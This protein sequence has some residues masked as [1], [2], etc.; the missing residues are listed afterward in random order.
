MLE[1]I[2]GTFSG[3]V[4]KLSGKSTITEKNI[5]IRKKNLSLRNFAVTMLIPIFACKRIHKHTY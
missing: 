4:K 1:K 5:E 3:I 2:T